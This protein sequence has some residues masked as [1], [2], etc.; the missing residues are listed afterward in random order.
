MST[1]DFLFYFL[2]KLIIQSTIN[3]YSGYSECAVP[4]FFLGIFITNF[5]SEY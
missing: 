1:V 2:F 3:F 4:I 5:I